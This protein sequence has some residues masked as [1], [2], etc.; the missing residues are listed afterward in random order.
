MIC[1]SCRL[2]L[3]ASLALVLGGMQQGLAHPHHRTHH[4]HVV[5]QPAP[6]LAQSYGYPYGSP[7]FDP[8]PDCRYPDGTPFDPD[9]IGGPNHVGDGG[10]AVNLGGNAP[11]G[12]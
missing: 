12:Y 7:G 2:A 4:S 6:R 11:C 8:G 3:A 10:P 9:I 1:A 5:R